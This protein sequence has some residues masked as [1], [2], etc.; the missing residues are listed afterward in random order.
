MVAVERVWSS[1][2]H[3]TNVAAGAAIGGGVIIR[4]VHVRASRG[5]SDRGAG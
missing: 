4:S 1:T 3:L 2:S 5:G